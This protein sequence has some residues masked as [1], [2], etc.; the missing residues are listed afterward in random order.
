MFQ[1][2]A[3]G[4]DDCLRR[5]LINELMCHFRL[6]CAA[7]TTKFGVDFEQYFAAELSVLA[8]MAADGLLHFDGQ[9]LHVNAAGKLLIRNI[10]M[11]FDAY[12]QRE[13]EA[14]QRYSRTI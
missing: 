3:L 14:A 9:V 1:G 6:D 10:C 8:A 12:L 5:A 2:I 13:S 4:F 7:F 11:V